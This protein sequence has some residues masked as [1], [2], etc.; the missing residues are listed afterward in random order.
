MKKILS[1]L[2]MVTII[3]GT[4]TCLCGINAFAA[5][6]YTTEV[7]K[8]VEI[9]L[10]SSV[11]YE[12]HFT[13]TEIDAVFTH[14]DGTVITLPGF[15]KE[16]MTWAVR[17]S[18]T[19]TG[20]WSYK[21]TCKDEANKGLFS[22]GV[23]EA[24]ATTSKNKLAQHGFIKTVDNQHYYSYDDGT[25]F[26]WL[27]DTHWQ[28]P[29]NES[30]EVCNYPGCTCGNQF[31]HMVDDRIEKG[32]NV[33]QTYFVP[34]SG[35]GEKSCWS[36]FKYKKPNT[37]IFNN[38]ID[39]M[40]EYLG[41]NGFVIAVGL[42]CH[43]STM[44]N[45]NWTREVYL[46]FAR[47]IVARYACYSIVWISGQEITNDKDAGEKGLTVFE[48]YCEMSS[49]IEELDGY[50]HPNSAHM[51]PAKGDAAMQQILDKSNWHDSWTIQGGHGGLN[52]PK[53]KDMYS[54]YYLACLSG[55]FK[56]FIESELDYEDIN[57]GGFT[58]YDASRIGAWKA[59]LCGSAGFTY[60]VTGIWANCFSTNGFTG[61]YT[62]G[63][64]SYNYEPWYMGLDKPGSF[65]MTY[66][67]N[68]FE[69]IHEW[70]NLVPLYK[71]VTYGDFLKDEHITFARNLEGT[72]YVGLINKT[73]TKSIG[74]LK[75]LDDSKTYTAY[76][77]NARN[78]KYIKIE[79]NIKTVN[80]EYKMPEKPDNRDWIF[81]ITSDGIDAHYE[82]NTFVD[83]NPNYDQVAIKGTAVTPVSVTA[84]GGITYKGSKK[85]S[86][87]M[88]DKTINLYDNDATTVWEPF[89]DRTTQT[90]IYDLGKA[91]NLSHVTITP[92]DNHI[93]PKF[94]I[95]G[96]NDM[97]LWNIITDTSVRSV[98]NP[99]KGSEPLAGAY[100]YVK[101]ILL[102]AET[103]TDVKSKADAEAKPYECYYNSFTEN[104]YS[105]TR[106]KDVVV[107][108]E[109]EATEI[110]TESLVASTLGSANQ[111]DANNGNGE[112]DGTTDGGNNGGN[113]NTGNN[114]GSDNG[115]ATATPAGT[116]NGDKPAGNN[117]V[118]FIIIG[119][120]AVV[121]IGAVVA[122]VVIK[123]KKSQK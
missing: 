41:E 65:E 110:K 35:N 37:E 61:W 39:T 90:F 42:G 64:K 73:E 57:C 112:G 102:N 60:G 79:D 111:G 69:D 30:T 76:W 14:A 104:G 92:D 107:Y 88:T 63:G 123:K 22:E 71:N 117:T 67:K 74:T 103:L 15:W 121:V 101:I 95:E 105:V 6:D 66:M 40:F 70:W 58:G 84:V 98:E 1:L 27:G 16:G 44:S 59:I 120:A 5:A 38:K 87:T 3:F 109:G 9:Q 62:P 85:A 34:G 28:A 94:R 106:I 75:L 56:P 77:Y 50:K 36:D 122:V 25:P 118:M 23:I 115:Q 68:F 55:K 2:I 108:A 113:T 100:R 78:G 49:H 45:T 46:R 99:G 119:V 11:A 12:N 114:G 4:L 19:K 86:Q 29:M 21:I 48:A 43:N 72:T 47:Y 52:R 82:E 13:D 8:P 116:D 17:F 20:S 26:F 83:L 80:G 24:V 33:Y 93:I 32:F 53:Q 7:W 10:T 89:S 91:Y 81:L 18:P 51:Y 31:K 96:S 54:S 97:S